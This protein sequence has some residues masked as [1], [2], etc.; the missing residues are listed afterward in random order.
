MSTRKTSGEKRD[1]IRLVN[2]QF[3]EYGLTEAA[4]KLFKGVTINL[5]ETGMCLMVFNEVHEGQKIVIKSGLVVKKPLIIQWVKELDYDIYKV[6]L[7][8]SE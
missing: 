8:F 7:R 3:V 5:S 1:K 4:V 6:G 2:Y